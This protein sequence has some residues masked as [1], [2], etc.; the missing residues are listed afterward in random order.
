MKDIPYYASVEVEGELFFSA[1][2]INALFKMNIESKK[3]TYIGRVKDEKRE[4][5]LHRFAL[6]HGNCIFFIPSCGDYIAKLQLDTLE[7]S[8]IELSQKECI[9]YEGKFAD[10]VYVEDSVWLIPSNY[11]VLLRLDLNEGKIEKFDNWPKELECNNER[12]LWFVAAC[13]ISHYICMCPYE[14]KYFVVFDLESKKMSVWEWNYPKHAFSAMI[15]HKDVIW[16]L[17]EREYPCV[18]GYSVVTAEKYE[19]ETGEQVDENIW[20][21]HDG[22]AVVGD[23]IILTPFETDH[24]LAVDTRTRKVI[25]VTLSKRRW[26]KKFQYPLYNCIRYVSGGLIVISLFHEY[27]LFID[28]HS[29]EVEEIKTVADNET[30]VL[31]IKDVLSQR[32]NDKKSRAQEDLLNE[33]TWELSDYLQ[34]LC[35]CNNEQE[36]NKETI[37][38]GDN[39]Y[40]KTV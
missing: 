39:I 22:A 9:G 20:C 1:M 34:A 18:V 7:I 29:Y 19:I 30:S 35:M 5:G 25:T 17:P 26:A 21:L 27:V 6:K 23:Y 24:W 15:F 16:F 36:A 40:R 28:L 37:L 14:A 4:N 38:C 13:C 3:V 12:V 31:V 32:R 11:S 10:I 8:S 2:R 33:N